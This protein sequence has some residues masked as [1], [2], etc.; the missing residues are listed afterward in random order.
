MS[1][2]WC[3]QCGR[4]LRPLPGAFLELMQQF[5]GTACSDCAR[6]LCDSCKPPPS[7]G[8]TLMCTR[9]GG[10]LDPVFARD[11]EAIHQKHMKA[12]L[13]WC[14]RFREQPIGVQIGNRSPTTLSSSREESPG[15]SFFFDLIADGRLRE[16]EQDADRPGTYGFEFNSHV[17]G[18]QEND[19][20]SLGYEVSGIDDDGERLV[21]QRQPGRPARRSPF[22][23]RRVA[24]HRTGIA[25]GSRYAVREN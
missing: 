10:S 22:A 21:I 5:E 15:G 4:Q 18:T 17:R 9:C 3:S 14:D 13:A 20:F 23:S 11:L 12:I 2:V 1:M 6:I 8:G 19:R 24:R 25:G 7:Q 16:I